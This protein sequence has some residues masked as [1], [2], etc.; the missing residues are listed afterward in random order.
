MA[1]DIAAAV[2]RLNDQLPLQARQQ[3]LPAPLVEVHRALL[4]SLAERGRPLSR[5]EIGEI[6]PDGAVDPAL[7][8]LGHD[9]LA[10][11]SPGGSEALGAY[12]MTVE[13]T[14]HRLRLGAVS[15]NAMCALDALSVAPMFGTEV[16]IDSRCHLTGEP[17]H[18]R[19]RDHEILEASPSTEVRVGVRWQQPS[20]PAAHSM[21][22]EMVFLKD[23]A[24][25]RS[26][27]AGDTTNISLF[28]LSEAVDFGAAFFKPLL[29]AQAQ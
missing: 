26:W 2:A 6:L 28:T 5:D 4:R 25:A 16:E 14:P 17:I 23:A 19:Q 10:V 27:Q 1:A 9:D 13:S 29:E 18:V 3:A 8:R 21:C 11:L 22:M 7:R 12:P 20:G 24:T 15:V